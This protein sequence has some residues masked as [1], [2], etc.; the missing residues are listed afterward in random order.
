MRFLPFSMKVKVSTKQSFQTALEK[1]LGEWPCWLDACCIRTQK[2]SAYFQL[3]VGQPVTLQD[4]WYGGCWPLC[5][6]ARASNSSYR[7]CSAAIAIVLVWEWAAEETGASPQLKAG[8]GFSL[9]LVYGKVTEQS[10]CKDCKT[11]YFYLKMLCLL[12][13]VKRWLL[14]SE[15]NFYGLNTSVIRRE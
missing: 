6:L 8:G 5:V 4:S 9:Q 2:N 1:M 15:W 7:E 14:L 10:S 11:D 12:S 13:F 3:E